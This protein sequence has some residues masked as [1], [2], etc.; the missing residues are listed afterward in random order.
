M[1]AIR[2][3]FCVI[4]QV[5]ISPDD[6]LFV[7][8]CNHRFHGNCI[9]DLL[10]ATHCA[11]CPIC[12]R[13]MFNV[14]EPTGPASPAGQAN[15]TTQAAPANQT[16][17]ANQANQTNPIVDPEVKYEF[18]YITPILQLI[19]TNIGVLESY[20]ATV[21]HDAKVVFKKA[22][23]KIHQCVCDI[24]NDYV[25]MLDNPTSIN[26]MIKHNLL[27]VLMHEIKSMDFR[28]YESTYRS[29]Q[30]IFHLIHC[31]TL[32]NSVQLINEHIFEI[33][34]QIRDDHDQD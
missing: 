22:T 6:N 8:I 13:N 28:L 4:C 33:V 14:E 19:N 1:A 23:K 29:L 30:S 18:S 25:R 26:Q 12:R 32:P 11:L 9:Q 5:E 16:M 10:N 34:T 17:P 2:A 21:I 27:F 20:S 3:A 15:Q 24:L 31:I 7:S